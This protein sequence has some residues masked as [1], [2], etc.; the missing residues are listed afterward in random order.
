MG[1]EKRAVEQAAAKERRLE[2]ARLVELNRQAKLVSDPMALTNLTYSPP[3]RSI[4]EEEL[5]DMRE[6]VRRHRKQLS[7]AP[8][9]PRSTG[10]LSLP[11]SLNNIRTPSHRSTRKRGSGSG[12][13]KR[14]HRNRV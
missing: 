8:V 4:S 9:T 10:K 5:E 11:R 3:K 7:N 12:K 1:S 2:M 6:F 13:T 14:R